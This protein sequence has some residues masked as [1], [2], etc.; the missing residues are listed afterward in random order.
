MLTCRRLLPLL[1]L[2]ACSPRPGQPGPDVLELLA[3]LSSLCA[4]YDNAATI[5]RMDT[6][7][8]VQGEWHQQADAFC[9]NAAIPDTL[10]L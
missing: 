5:A 7:T 6:A 1:F 4:G 9:V 2:A 8:G 10:Q 3:Q